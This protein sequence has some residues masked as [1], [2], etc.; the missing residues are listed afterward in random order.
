M[1]ASVIRPGLYGIRRQG[2]IRIEGAEG[3]H[4]GD[5]LVHHVLPLGAFAGGHPAEGHAARVDA[6]EL[7]EVVEHGEAPAGVVV[8]RRV[9]AVGRVAAA[10]DDAV[11]AALER[12]DDEERVDASRA[13]E[14]DQSHV[15][16]HVQAAGA[17]Q[18][19]AGV[20]APVADE[21][22][23]AGFELVAHDGRHS[24]AQSALISL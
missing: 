18:V 20:G 10:D 7:H 17:G 11:G 13:G 9:V 21:G 15:A 4:V 12:L 16:R 6:H 24:H 14:A 2:A 19:G 1:V 22:R 23:D 5:G 8:A 3:A